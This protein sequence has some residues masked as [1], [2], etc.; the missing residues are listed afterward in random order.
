M[1]ALTLFLVIVLN[2]HKEVS[3]P[4]K[5]LVPFAFNYTHFTSMLTLER[6][7]NFLIMVCLTL[8]YFS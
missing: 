5:G 7:L 1:F 2:L 6:I 4:Q 8:V 3:A